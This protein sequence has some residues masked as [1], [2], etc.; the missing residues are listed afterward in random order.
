M[1]VSGAIVGQGAV[2]SHLVAVGA[3]A[4]GLE[5]L[6]TILGDL[7]ADLPACVLVVV[8]MPSSGESALPR[9]VN[10]VSPLPAKH[11]TDGDLLEAGT[12]LIAP[13]D[14]HL[15]VDGTRAAVRRGP[16]VNRSRPA[17]DPLFQSVALHAADRGIGIVLSGALDDGAA[18]LAAIA[19]AGGTTIVQEP[20]EAAYPGMPEAALERAVVQHRL[21]AKRIAWAIETSIGSEAAG[22]NGRPR[23]ASRLEKE[24][25]MSELDE[26]FVTT[27]ELGTEVSTFG[28]PACGGTLWEL[29]EGDGFRFRCRVGHAYSPK[30]LLEGQA[31]SVEEGL[32]IAV[33]ALDEQATLANRLAEQAKRNGQGTSQGRFQQQAKLAERH[34]RA[35]R[36][37]LM[38][39]P[40]APTHG[41]PTGEPER[42]ASEVG[43]G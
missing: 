23:H 39:E 19:A 20:S 18:G 1:S 24:L 30:T 42:T 2:P 41:E 10:R 34:A 29:K 33:R 22:T 27:D 17:V 32:W 31:A 43:E 21:P 15:T 16:T 14:H 13:P 11:A 3:S 6:M 8:H 7:S 5:P 28:C 40:G 35:I 37:M 12:I 26:D 9:I 25:L 36:E 38:M 4:G